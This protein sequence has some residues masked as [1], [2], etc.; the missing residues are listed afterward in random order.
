MATDWVVVEGADPE[1]GF[2]EWTVDDLASLDSKAERRAW[3]FTPT[4]LGVSAN[5]A[6]DSA[7][8]TWGNWAA[9]DF[10]FLPDEVNVIPELTQGDDDEWQIQPEPD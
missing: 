3:K 5:A 7:A 4:A 1:E 2:S 8:P 6:A 9:E 10:D